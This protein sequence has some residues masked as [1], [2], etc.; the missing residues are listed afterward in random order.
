M[1]FTRGGENKRKRFV[2]QYYSLSKRVNI[3][4]QDGRDHSYSLFEIQQ[5]LRRIYS[6]FG[7]G[8]FPLAN[9]VENM[10]NGTEQ[11]GLG[12]IILSEGKND[13]SHAQGA[14]YLGVVLENTGY[15][16]WNGKNRGIE[17]RLLD[18]DFELSTIEK[19]L[20]RSMA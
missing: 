17:W 3:Q 9:N 20:N 15:L 16:E 7:M 8:Y 18:T 1:A 4:N 10:G 13:I 14:S 11:M 6:E 5:I 12:M 19:R 2:W